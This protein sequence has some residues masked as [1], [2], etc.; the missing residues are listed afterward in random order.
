MFRAVAT[1]AIFIMTAHNCLF[2][3]EHAQWHKAFSANMIFF[4]TIRIYFI[5]TWNSFI[6]QNG[7]QNWKVLLVDMGTLCL[8][9]LTMTDDADL[10][11]YRPGRGIPSQRIEMSKEQFTKDD[12]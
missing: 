3:H 9:A 12:P 7:I 5:A 10:R 4:R 6:I 2:D 8:T 11:A 1:A